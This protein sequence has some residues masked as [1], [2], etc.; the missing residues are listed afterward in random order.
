MRLCRRC[1]ILKGAAPYNLP[2]HNPRAGGGAVGGRCRGAAL[3]RV[4]GSSTTPFLPFLNPDM[5]PEHYYQ[6]HSLLYWSIIS[7]AGAPLLVG[8]DPCLAALAG[9]LNRLLWATIGG[10]PGIALRR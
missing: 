1:C 9:P 10:R 4:L 2:P 8:L 5:S 6:Q 7:V 3:P